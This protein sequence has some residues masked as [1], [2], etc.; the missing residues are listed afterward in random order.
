MTEVIGRAPVVMP[1]YWHKSQYA[2][3]V[4]SGQD[5]TYDE[6]AGQ[7]EIGWTFVAW[8]HWGGLYNGEMKPPDARARLPPHRA[9]PD[10]DPVTY[11]PRVLG[12]DL[13][14]H[15]TTAH[16]S[17]ADLQRR[18]YGRPDRADFEFEGRPLNLLP[19]AR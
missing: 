14:P 6:E 17:D 5:H 16:S 2:A 13:P 8:S 1:I 19:S 9:G 3:E 11:D 10:L 15:D 18:A 4:R 7:V 12:L